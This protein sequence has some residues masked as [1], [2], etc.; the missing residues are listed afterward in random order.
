M[1]VAL[2]EDEDENVGVDDRVGWE[3]EGCAER[4]AVVG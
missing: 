1:E 3:V 4:R 2:G